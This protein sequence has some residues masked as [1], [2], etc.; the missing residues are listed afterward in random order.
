MSDTKKTSTES[1]QNP[2]GSK[3]TGHQVLIGE[4]VYSEGK[5]PVTIRPATGPSPSKNEKE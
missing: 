3:D 2:R 5:M 4:H 1:T